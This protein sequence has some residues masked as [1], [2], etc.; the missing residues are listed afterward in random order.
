MLYF[1]HSYKIPASR[2]FPSSPSSPCLVHPIPHPKPPLTHR[3]PSFPRKIDATIIHSPPLDP[4]YARTV[5][6]PLGCMYRRAPEPRSRCLSFPS[7]SPRRSCTL[8]VLCHARARRS[9]VLS[10]IVTPGRR[11]TL[12]RA[13]TTALLQSEVGEARREPHTTSDA[14]LL[15]VKP[16]P[17]IGLG[18]AS[19]PLADLPTSIWKIVRWRPAT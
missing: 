12:G 3:S 17:A 4:V 14:S 8:S 15:I 18:R 9:F 16:S 11:C 5:Y 7:R 19:F 2:P 13:P 1:I 6:G 10:L